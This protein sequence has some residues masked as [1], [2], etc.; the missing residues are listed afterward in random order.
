MLDS[1]S[2]L[3]YIKPQQSYIWY[4]DLLMIN[5]VGIDMP[6]TDNPQRS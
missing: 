2:S 6:H 4:I 1:G 5:E 3:Y